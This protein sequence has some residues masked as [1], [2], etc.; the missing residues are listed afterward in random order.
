MVFQGRTIFPGLRENVRDYQVRIPHFLRDVRQLLFLGIGLPLHARAGFDTAGSPG[1][2]NVD[3]ENRC[4]VGFMSGVAV[5][6]RRG[7]NLPA[8][9]ERSQV[10]FEV[11]EVGWYLSLEIHAR[12]PYAKSKF[13]SCGFFW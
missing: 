3:V 10:I 9:S 12:H 13:Y 2:E 8:A 6:C 1:L 5:D 7:K 4:I 11:N